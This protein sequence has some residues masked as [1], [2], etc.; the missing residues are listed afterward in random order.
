MKKRRS[1][2]GGEEGEELGD[3]ETQP[4]AL[5]PTAHSPTA[6]Q[7]TALQP[8]AYSRTPYTLQPTALHRTAEGKRA[9]NWVTASD[10]AASPFLSKSACL[11]CFI[12]SRRFFISSPLWTSSVYGPPACVYAN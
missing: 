5:H 4:T 2:L 7:P 8:T 10:A 12:G 6:L 3:G 1:D 11:W 9:R